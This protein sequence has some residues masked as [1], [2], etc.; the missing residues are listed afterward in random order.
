VL[1]QQDRYISYEGNKA[2]HAP[3]NVLFAV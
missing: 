3:N 1:A 2:D